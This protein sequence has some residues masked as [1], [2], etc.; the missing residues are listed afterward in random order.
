MKRLAILGASGHG[1]V[2]ADIAELM[3][4]QDIEFY[5]DAWPSLDIIGAWPV[6]GNTDK[7]VSCIEEYDGFFIAIGNNTIR[8]KKFNQVNKSSTLP[9]TLLHPSAVISKYAVI[10]EGTVVMANAVINPFTTIDQVCIVNTG[11]TLDHDCYLGIASHISPGANL[12]GG[13]V[14]G[15]ESWV[16]VGACVKQQVVIGQNVVIGAGASVVNNIESGLTVVG[17][18]AKPI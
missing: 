7:L 10:K 16:G 9:V 3:G 15:S 6:I 2:A 17:I 13:V 5:D 18:P 4:W 1:K 12:S 8:L 11:S 14:V